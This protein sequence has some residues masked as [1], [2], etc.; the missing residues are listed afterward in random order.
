MERQKVEQQKLKEL[1]EIKQLKQRQQELREAASSADEEKK[2]PEVEKEKL[3]LQQ[4]VVSE[5]TVPT[6]KPEDIEIPKPKR[7]LSAESSKAVV[8]PPK[9]PSP[10]RRRVSTS[11]S[12]SP[13]RK[14]SISPR[15]S[16]PRRRSPSPRR[17]PLSP[18][19]RSPS[20][21]R[22]SPLRRP[23]PRRRF[24]SSPDSGGSKSPSPRRRKRSPTAKPSK[25][26]IGN[27]T[28][29]INKDHILEIF[30][31]YGRI[32]SIDLPLD[33]KNYLPRGYAYVE[34]DHKDDAK[35]ALRHMNGGWI[36]GQEVTAKEV[37]RPSS[38]PSGNRG[39][40][41]AGAPL[42]SRAPQWQNRRRSPP[43]FGNR[44]FSPRRS[45]SPR[46]RSLSPRGIPR[47]RRGSVTSGSSSPSPPPKR[48]SSPPSA[49]KRRRYSRSSS[50]SD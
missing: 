28:R 46:R 17:R 20:P 43:R 42:R 29:N 34:F 18:R 7:D 22:R 26:H 49:G 39:R 48:R 21:R 14:R 50:D 1:E 44:R 41:G 19:K 11:R 32:R 35:V 25:L 2:N 16:P 10:P 40:G 6:V 15:R 9:R 30:S 45:R 4:T 36:D 38:P 31:V 24:S 5:K 12:A 33:T 13:V 27:L 23:P 8:V 47:R 3:K 37:L